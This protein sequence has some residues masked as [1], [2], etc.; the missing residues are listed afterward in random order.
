MTETESAV[1]INCKN[2]ASIGGGYSANSISEETSKR[3]TSLRFLL[4]MLVVTI[5]NNFSYT[6]IAK[7]NMTIVFVPSTISIWVQY[8]ISNSLASCAVPIFFMFS[9]YLQFKKNDGYGV[10]LR[11]RFRSLVI[12]YFLWM[13]FGII[14][15]NLL[16]FLA[17]YFMPSLLQNSDEFFIY[18]NPLD[19][20]WAFIGNYSK[21]PDVKVP[22][23]GV[24]WY[25]RDL[26]ILVLISPLFK[27]V[28]KKFPLE[29]LLVSSVCWLG[30]IRPLIV[31]PGALFFYTLGY[32]WAEEK[33]DFFAIADRFRW[34]MLLP[35]FALLIF[36]KRNVYPD[37]QAVSAASLFCSIFIALKFS[38]V[39]LKSK[40]FY[41]WAKYL[42]GFSFF[43]Y[44][45]HG[46]AFLECIKKAWLRF[47]PLKNG[48]LCLLEYFCVSIIVIVIGTGIGIVLK[49]I[50]PKL[51][52]LLSGGR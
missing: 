29:L 4:A 15:Y 18:N 12:P 35:I 49:R 22:F 40:K 27:K 38:L 33:I 45:I 7:W 44:V 30:G 36:L 50:F 46:T 23:V 32:F 26:F 41:A 17:A 9:S 52:A 20:L 8:I 10:L 11:K 42:S 47:L 14:S 6:E 2:N 21:Y 24:L 19:W 25:V 51:F 34:K 28:I 39:I 13:I 1:D 16:K 48:G 43:L 31:D 37:T 3:I 5:H